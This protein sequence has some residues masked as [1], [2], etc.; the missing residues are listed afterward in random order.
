MERYE[1]DVMDLR[2]TLAETRQELKI[3]KEIYDKDMREFKEDILNIVKE[4]KKISDGMLEFR[5]EL[6]KLTSIDIKRVAI[7][8]VTVWSMSIINYMGK[9]WISSKIDTRPITLSLEDKDNGY[10][11]CSERPER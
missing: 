5:N 11:N 3:H 9:T 10:K 7:F 2:V 4:Q 1:R 8:A 6:R